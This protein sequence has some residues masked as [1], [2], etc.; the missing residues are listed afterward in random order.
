MVLWLILPTIRLYR[1]FGKLFSP[2][3]C[4]VTFSAVRILLVFKFVT[5]AVKI[6]FVQDT[7]LNVM[8]CNCAS[9]LLQWLHQG[10]IHIIILRDNT[11]LPAFVTLEFG[12]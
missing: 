5:S 12:L 9:G 10:V 2:S 6:F 11:L 4:R 8:W 3:C 7:Y 1:F